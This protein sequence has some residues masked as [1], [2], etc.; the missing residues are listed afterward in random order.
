MNMKILRGGPASGTS[1]HQL[2][3]LDPPAGMTVLSALF[4]IRDRIDGTLAFRYS[5]R[6][7]VCGS[8]A[9]SING[10]PR[11]ACRTQLSA[12]SRERE[13][14]VEPLPNLPV[15]RDLVVDMG[16][17]FEKYRA[18]RPWLRGAIDFTGG[19][20]E[21]PMAPESVR[22]LELYTS[23]I[24]CAACHGAC[25]VCSAIPDFAGPAPLAKLYR[26]AIDPRDAEGTRRLREADTP[27]GWPA[28]E[29]HLKCKAVCPRGVPP[30]IA[31]GRSREIL[32]KEGER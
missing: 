27:G 12:F 25:P 14:L 6:G 21:T 29:F 24:L 17:F 20:R 10:V 13:V 11:L 2:Y 32:G 23:C 8:C 3:E 16:P 30:N 15:L 4:W 28:C 19:S 22:E 7:A 1:R 18:L 9:M 31:I 5:C 26:F